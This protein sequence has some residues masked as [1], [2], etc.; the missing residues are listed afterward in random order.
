MKCNQCISLIPKVVTDDV[1]INEKNDFFEH[2]D[3]CPSCKAEY[4][5]EKDALDNLKSSIL[6]PNISTSNKL[7]DIMLNIDENRYKNKNANK[8][9]FFNIY[10]KKYGLI[11]TSFLLIIFLVTM[12]SHYVL[13]DSNVSLAPI[14]KKEKSTELKID[15]TPNSAKLVPID[16]IPKHEIKDLPLNYSYKGFYDK[17]NLIITNR[18]NNF[19]DASIYNIKTG[20]SKPLVKA[21]LEKGSLQYVEAEGNL[22]VW[23]EYMQVGTEVKWELAYKN[24][25]DD[26]NNILA[27]GVLDNKGNIT[28]SRLPIISISKGKVVARIEDNNN[29]KLMVYNLKEN[30]SK[31]IKSLKN[32]DISYLQCDE[33]MVFWSETSE[34][35]HNPRLYNICSYNLKS[36]EI[37]L[38]TQKSDS[39]DFYVKKDKLFFAEDNKL[40]L[41]DLKSRI[42]TDIVSKELPAFKD[43]I[44]KG[45]YIYSTGDFFLSDQYM[46]FKNDKKIYIYD[47][48]NNVFYNIMDYM[49]G[50]ITGINYILFNNDGI[51]VKYVAKGDIK[52]VYIDL[53]K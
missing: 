7:S 14:A 46:E 44:D 13:K 8:L 16:R 21:I 6:S 45:F 26:K 12:V 4:L 10:L 37:K 38:I 34:S 50:P 17:E 42:N 5:F 28:I 41:Y 19:S 32:Q 11:A 23:V 49:D 9:S 1:D 30:S 3:M 29:T 40:K 18:N 36:E 35:Q 39:S 51:V 52:T 20:T 2:I 31:E 15:M 47:L 48:K 27:E 24:T 33:D 53:S 25:S 22:V 43:I